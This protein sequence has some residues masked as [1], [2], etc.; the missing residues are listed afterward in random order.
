MRTRRATSNCVR[1]L[2]AGEGHQTGHALAAA[3]DRP[4]SLASSSALV[5]TGC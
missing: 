3:Q 1:R 2:P 5:A 4:S